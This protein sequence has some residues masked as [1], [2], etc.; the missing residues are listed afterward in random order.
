MK[1][2]RIIIL[3]VAV[4]AAEADQMPSAC[5]NWLSL[6]RWADVSA[7]DRGI[8]LVSLDAPLVQVVDQRLGHL[9]D[10]HRIAG[11]HARL[12]AIWCEGRDRLHQVHHQRRSGAGS[13]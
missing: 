8:T 7:G 2:A 6:G 4:V 13:L 9:G 3:A 12:G 10:D 1:P 5:R 11:R